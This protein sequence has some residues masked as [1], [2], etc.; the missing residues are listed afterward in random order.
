MYSHRMVLIFWLITSTLEKM[1]YKSHVVA[2][3]L[4]SLTKT[5]WQSGALGFHVVM[6]TRVMDILLYSLKDYSVNQMLGYTKEKNFCDKETLFKT[7][8]FLGNPTRQKWKHC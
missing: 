2:V 8:K 1:F 6:V 5:C 7:R 4:I 3:V